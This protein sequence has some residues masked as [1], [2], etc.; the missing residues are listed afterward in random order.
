MVGSGY[1]VENPVV[2]LEKT[3]GVLNMEQIGRTDGDGGDQSNR[4]SFTG[5]DFSDLPH[6]FVE[7]GRELGIEVYNHER[8]SAPYFMASDNRPFAAAG[9]PAHTFCVVYQYADYHGVGDHWDKV[10]FQNMERTVRMLALGLIRLANSDAEP[11][12]NEDNPAVERYVEAWRALRGGG[13]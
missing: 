3:V 13:G 11:R 12:W 2:P 6:F 4:G 10:N 1:Y 5:F 9:I 7:A 8:N